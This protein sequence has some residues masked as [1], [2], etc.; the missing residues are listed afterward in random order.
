MHLMEKAE[1]VLEAGNDARKAMDVL[2]R[3]SLER[4]CC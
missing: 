3:K 4:S 2:K 1:I